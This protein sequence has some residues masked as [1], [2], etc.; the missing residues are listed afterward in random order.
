VLMHLQIRDF[1]LI[2]RVELEFGGGLTVVT[3]ETGAGKSIIVDALLLA[4]GGRAAIDVVRHGAERAEISASFDISA[5]SA[6]CAWLNEQAIDCDGECLLRR[7]IGADGRSRGYI[8]GQAVPLQV[9]RALGELLVDIHGQHEFQSLGRAAVQRALLDAHAGNE[10]LIE[11]IAQAH[12]SL[13]ELSE[14][15]RELEAKAASRASQLELLRYQVRELD[16]LALQPGEVEEL[17]AEQRRHANRGRLGEGL[18]QILDQ[19]YDSDSGSAYALIS[20]SQTQLRNLAALDANLTPAAALLGEAS[21]TLTEAADF[22]RRSFAELDV[23]PARQDWVEKRLASVED[24]ARKH[25]V[26]RAD[27]AATRER[28]VRELE[29]LETS[30][31]K[32]GLL[33]AELAKASARYAE[34]AGA[35]TKSRRRAAKSLSTAVSALMH[36]LG[37]TGGRFDAKVT[38]TV[39]LAVRREGADDIEFEVTANPGQPLKALSR[40]ASGGELSRIGLAI[41]VAAANRVVIPCMVFDEIDAGVGGGVAEIVGRQLRGLGERVQVLCVTHLPQVASQAHG[42][43]RVNKITDG[44]STRTAATALGT[45]ERVEELARMLGGVEITARAREHAREMLR[46]AGQA[47]RSG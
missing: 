1:A 17:M 13:S 37:M 8:N 10:E 3:G 9:L 6:A 19:L 42:H 2:D 26:T 27:V 5:D 39:P 45:A 31:T 47:A 32:L 38:T 15:H 33:Q 30:E 46:L 12:S 24:L 35:L 43:L 34:I 16:A 44:K 29:S 23:D 41:Q 28:L 21:L 14:R 25:K 18:Q 36:S 40:V 22:A 11:K 4:T 7:S 20:R